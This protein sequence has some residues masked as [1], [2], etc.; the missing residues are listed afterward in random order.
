MLPSNTVMS[1]AP[2]QLRNLQNSYNTALSPCKI[3]PLGPMSLLVQGLCWISQN[4]WKQLVLITQPRN[5][6]TFLK[7]SGESVPQ[8]K[9]V[10]LYN[11]IDLPNVFKGIVC[12]VMWYKCLCLVIKDHMELSTPFLQECVYVCIYAK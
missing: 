10:S 11:Y 8:Q 12:C 2:Y 1:S 9:S 5:I 4:F 7:T 6:H 3:M